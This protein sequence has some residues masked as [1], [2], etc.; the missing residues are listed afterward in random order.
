M[1]MTTTVKTCIHSFSS[2]L[3]IFLILVS[4]CDLVGE[5]GSGN[6]IRQER[7]VSSFTSLDVSGAFKV[8]LSQGATQ[9][10]IIEADDNLMEKIETEVTGGKLRIYNKRHI[11]NAKSLNVYITATEMNAIELSGAVDLQT[12]TRLTG[13][14]FSLDVSGASDSKLEL[15]VQKLDVSSSG[16][17]NLQLIGTATEVKMDVSGAVDLHAFDLLTEK[18][19]LNMSGAGEADINVKNELNADI[20][21]AATVRYKG[22]PA[23]LVED[24]SGAGSVRKAD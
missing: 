19:F 1:V 3:I 10:V 20:S 9:S 24:I 13:S 7:K 21:G 4:S 2:L 17:S 8:Y 16:G 6:V 11:M 23:K 12:Q 18:F 14:S 15:A 5:Q 22:N